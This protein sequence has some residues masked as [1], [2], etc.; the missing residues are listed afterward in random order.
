MLATTTRKLIIEFP[1][2]TS[3]EESFPRNAS[4]GL[5]TLNDKFAL[6]VIKRLL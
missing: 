6:A 1:E 3:S 5:K 2:V 4:K